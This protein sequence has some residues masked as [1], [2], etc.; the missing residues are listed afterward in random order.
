LASTRVAQPW[1]AR[2][3]EKR[4]EKKKERETIITYRKMSISSLNY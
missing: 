4:K 3:G 1:I 2:S